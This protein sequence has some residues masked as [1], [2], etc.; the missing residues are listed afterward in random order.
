MDEISELKSQIAALQTRLSTLE[1]RGSRK[2]IPAPSEPATTVTYTTPPVTLD[3][4][5]EAELLE[6]REICRR[7]FPEWCSSQ[8][9]ILTFARFYGEDDR[10]REEAEWLEQFLRAIIAISGMRRLE[11]PD[12][13]RY[14]PAIIDM[15]TDHLRAIGKTGDLRAGPFVMACFCMGVPVSGVGVA[16]A[17]ISIGLSRDIGAPA[18]PS[19]WRHTLK[20]REL[21]QQFPVT[22]PKFCG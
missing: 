10:R 21:P 2:V 9:F 18:D 12:T 14:L 8:G 6:L 16:A 7:A 11:K 1:E 19:A 4:P 3:L 13:R 20:A 22:T 17:S 15:C 5:D